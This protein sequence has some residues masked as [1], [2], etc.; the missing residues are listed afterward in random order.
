[1]G[2]LE[3]WL[4]NTVRIQKQNVKNILSYRAQTNL[5]KYES[6]N[7]ES[8]ALSFRNLELIYI[9]W[10]FGLAVSLAVFGGEILWFIRSSF[11]G[12]L[13]RMKCRN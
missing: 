11:V 13:W 4:S 9:L 12:C 5:K 6:K 2:L 8:K 10:S 7:R 3:K 1:M